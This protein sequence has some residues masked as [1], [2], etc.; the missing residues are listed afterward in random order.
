MCTCSP[1]IFCSSPDITEV[2]RGKTSGFPKAINQI[3][4]KQKLGVKMDA[5]THVK[6]N[7]SAMANFNC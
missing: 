2:K 6:N 4:Q 1:F 7:D 3:F 5:Y